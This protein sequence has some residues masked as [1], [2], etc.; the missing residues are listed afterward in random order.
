MLTRDNI[1]EVIKFAHREKLFIFAD[2]VSHCD[3][4]GKRKNSPMPILFPGLSRQCLRRQQRIPF[5]QESDKRIGRPL[6]QVGTGF[7]LILFQGYDMIKPLF[8]VYSVSLEIRNQ[9]TWEN[10]D[11]EG[12]MLRLSIWIQKLR[13]F[14]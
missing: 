9:V 11:C 1:V 7:F 4:K 3:H 5:V 13:R 8:T 2:E 12:D 6:R 10:A 14:T